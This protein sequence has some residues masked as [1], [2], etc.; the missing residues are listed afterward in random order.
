MRTVKRQTLPL[1]TA[2]QNSLEELCLVY[3]YEKQYWLD[4]LKGWKYQGMLGTPRKIRDEFVK[5][6]YQSKY[7]LQARHWKLALQDACETWDKYW[8]ALFV[9]VRSNISHNKTM[10]QGERRYAYFLIKDYPQFADL[11]QGVNQKGNFE[12]DQNARRR[13][14][15]YVQQQIKKLKGKPPC[16][17]KSRIVKFDA[18]CYTLIEHKERQYLKLMSL[19]KGKRLVI[20]LLGKQ[21]IEGNLTIVS[22]KGKFDI[23]LT[24]AL[25]SFKPKEGLIEA[26]DFGYTEVATDTQGNCYGKNLGEILTKATQKRHEK[27]QKR[28]RIHAQEKK[29]RITNSLKA[30]HCRK[31]NLGAKKLNHNTKKIQSTLE[32][33]INTG[34][35]ELIK[36]RKPAILITENLTHL[37]TFNKPK[38]INRKFSSWMKGKLQERVSFKAL[39][40]GFRHEQVNPAFGSQLCPNCDFVDHGNRKGDIFK[41]LYCKHEDQADRVA[42]LNYAGRFGDSD[43]GLYM[44]YSQVKTILL[45]RFHRRLE[46]G[47]P[48]T[49]PG[50]TLETA[51]RTNSQEFVEITKLSQPGEQSSL[52]RAVNQRAKQNKHVFTRF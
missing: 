26:I 2:K 52:N 51:T 41:C 14:A 3:A 18:N 49:V 15:N 38:S 34:I 33:E 29:L 6:K 30:A 24:Q 8:Q 9:R 42:A 7:E 16:V 19:E 48:V 43:I 44:P 32:R 27:M 39:A 11:M 46:T 12:I 4:I 21:K 22:K 40:E 25:K 45:A 1:N 10:T 31:F 28:H 47:Q 17:K 13:V 50:R 23:C 37:F 20:P 36:K 5:E 35:N